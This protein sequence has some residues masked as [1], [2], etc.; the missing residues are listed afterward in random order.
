MK[1]LLIAI[2]IVREPSLETAE[3]QAM[4]KKDTVVGA[5]SNANR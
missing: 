1:I 3:T 4:N 2:S 5:A